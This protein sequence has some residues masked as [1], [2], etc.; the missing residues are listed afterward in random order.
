MNKAIKFRAW[1]LDN[2]IMYYSDKNES[3]GED[4]IHWEVEPDNVIFSE[5]QIIDSCPGGMGHRQEREWR[6]PKQALMRFIGM[7]DNNGADIYEGDTVHAWDD[8]AKIGEGSV[9][10]GIVEYSGAGF[11]LRDKQD[12]INHLWTNAGFFEIVG[13]VYENPESE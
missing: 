9:M 5:I 12:R 1:D 11:G 10:S 3:N 7:Q 8:G 13:N 2:Q 4:A 6:Q